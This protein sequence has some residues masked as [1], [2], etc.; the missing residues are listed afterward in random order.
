MWELEGDYYYVV[1]SGQQYDTL[2]YIP[3]IHD[4]A[5]GVQRI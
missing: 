5:T 2:L 1:N 4:I 3:Q